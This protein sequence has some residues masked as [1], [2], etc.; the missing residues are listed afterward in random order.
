MQPEKGQY[1]IY[2]EAELS[3]I[4][5][6]FAENDEL[7]YAVRNVLLQFP[8]SVPQQAMLSSQLNENVIAVL[9]KRLLPD[10][11]GTFP[12]GQLPSLLTTLNDNLKVLSPAEMK[13]HFAAKILE[14]EYLAQQFDVLEGKDPVS[15]VSISLERLGEM[16]TK[17]ADEQFADM[18]AYLFL[19]GY[20]DPMLGMIQNLAG[21]KEETADEQ[22]KRLT[23][24]S[25]K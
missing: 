10:L 6:T 13:P 17:T 21:T 1:F 7:L 16:H 12:L 8:L 11:A 2:S 4:K 22:K 18:T 24:D 5:N 9:R 25:S 3:L 19:L 14:V 15:D 23:Q 20:I